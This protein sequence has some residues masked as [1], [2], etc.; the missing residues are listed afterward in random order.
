MPK[1]PNYTA[2]SVHDLTHTEVV[3][4]SPDSRSSS[5]KRTSMDDCY[6]DE[7]EELVAESIVGTVDLDHGVVTIVNRNSNPNC[8]ASIFFES[9]AD[10]I[11]SSVDDDPEQLSALLTSPNIQHRAEGIVDDIAI[12]IWGDLPVYHVTIPIDSNGMPVGAHL[13]VFIRRIVVNERLTVPTSP[14]P[15]EGL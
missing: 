9:A 8:A 3:P 13:S 11:L 1:V 14:V 2:S 15:C 7:D 4:G 5:A 6:T 12:R 10:A